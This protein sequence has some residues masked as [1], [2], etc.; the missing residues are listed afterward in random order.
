MFFVSVFR[1]FVKWPADFLM[2]VITP[3][4]PNQRDAPSNKW[5]LLSCQSGRDEF[6]QW[7]GLFRS[8]CCRRRV[9]CYCWKVNCHSFSVRLC[10]T[11]G[12][13]MKARCCQ[14]LYG[15]APGPLSPAPCS[16]IYSH[17]KSVHEEK[18][19]KENKTKEKKINTSLLICLPPRNVGGDKHCYPHTN[20]AARDMARDGWLA[21]GEGLPLL[22]CQTSPVISQS[23][24]HQ[25]GQSKEDPSWAKELS[26]VCT[27][28]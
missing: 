19:P 8:W 20:W 13:N 7:W 12:S 3:I 24:T 14:V 27:L 4:F 5:M 1:V 21:G 9:E 16:L 23:Q 17:T 6:F 10:N 2:R 15:P 26:S 22:N 11:A 28:K 18:Y 25:K